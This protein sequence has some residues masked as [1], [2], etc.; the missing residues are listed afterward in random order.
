MAAVRGERQLVTTP[1]PEIA[2][3]SARGCSVPATV[4]LLWNNPRLHPPERRKTWLACDDH[5]TSLTQF[6]GARGFMRETES[7]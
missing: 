2:T 4:A 6:L 5:Q 1:A 7:L 3:C